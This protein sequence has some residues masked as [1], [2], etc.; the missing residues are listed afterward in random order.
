MSEKWRNWARTATARPL[1]VH[2][3]TSVDAV[4]GIVSEAAANGQRVRMVGS[5]HSFTTAAVADDVMLRPGG[6]VGIRSVDTDLNRVTV[7]A[8]T[9][10]TSLCEEL[11]RLGLA[12]ANMGDIRVQTLA[13]AIQT[14]THGTGKDTG[15]FADMVT[16]LEIV[17]GDGSVLQCNAD[18]NSDVFNAGR[19]GL[20]AFGIVTAITLQVVPKY[21]L[22]AHEF[23]STWDVALGSFDQWT[24]D[25]DHVEFYWFPHTNGCMVKHNDR[26]TDPASPPSRFSEWWDE[27]FMANTV[28]GA[29]CRFGRAA[30]GYVPLINRAVTKLASDRD[31][32]NESWRVFT[33]PRTVRFTEMEYAL[34]REALIPALKDLR[35][36]VDKKGWRISFPFEVR[37]VPADSAWLS[38]ATGRDTGYIASHAFDRTDR[39]WFVDVE[40]V[41]RD[42]DGRPHWGKLHTRRVDDLAPSYP[43]WVEAMQVRNRLDPN[44]V[45]ANEYTQTVLGD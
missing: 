8:G 25:H 44:R 30:P 29:T 15:T 1:I 34:P 41:F 5:G 6:L 16:D 28:F 24:K 39:T 37:S 23:S 33:T 31:F 17:T 32:T 14:G 22:H 4:S 2:T 40:D 13:G 7:E 45:F 9:D 42:Y 10:L 21:R 38:P 11:D 35:Q 43:H 12:L 26:T 27:S 3:P 20:G 19:V 18:T 36:L